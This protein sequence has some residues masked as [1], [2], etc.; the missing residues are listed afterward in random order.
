MG[1]TKDGAFEGEDT[2]RRKDQR[3]QCIKGGQL[4]EPSDGCGTIS[5][6]R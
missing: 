5:Q 4:P 6:D 2:K 3:G 1:G